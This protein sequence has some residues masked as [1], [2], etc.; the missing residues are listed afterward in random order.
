MYQIAAEDVDGRKGAIGETRS[1][2][3]A[4]PA[5]EK[6]LDIL[7]L[8]SKEENGLSRKDIAERL[9]RTIGEI[10]RMIDCLVRR[11]YIVQVDDVFILSTRLFELSHSFPPTRRLLSEA[12]PR[13]RAL[14]EKTEQSCHLSVL[15]RM[16]QLVIAQSDTPE[17]VGFSIKVGS[18]LD[19][20]KSASGRVLVAFQERSDVERLM[21][22]ISP[23]LRAEELG[24]YEEEFG[25]I[26]SKGFA[27]MKSTQFS[28][29]RAI[30][31]PIFDLDGH[32]IAAL[33]VP[34]VA[35][36]DDSERPSHAA[37]QVELAATASEMNAALGI[38]THS[39]I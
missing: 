34:Y 18:K 31:Y 19:I 23:G 17:G 12:A 25:R 24:N 8:L 36:L 7:E 20:L 29:V 5:L 9:G 14:A 11:S 2:Q 33:T 35:R 21:K 3:Y 1:A 30:S 28:G 15:S 4:A 38:G 16:S 32:A 27:N 37:V 13:M 26:R 6:G 10:F 39:Q 22:Q